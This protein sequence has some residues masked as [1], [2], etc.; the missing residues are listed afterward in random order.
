[1][2][3]NV[4]TTDET[5]GNSETGKGNRASR[6]AAGPVQDMT[7][8]ITPKKERKT[9]ERRTNEARYADPV[10][11]FMSRSFGNG[12]EEFLDTDP[13]PG[14]SY[15]SGEWTFLRAAKKPLIQAFH[16]VTDPETG[17]IDETRSYS[18]E[19]IKT[20]RLYFRGSKAR[21]SGQ[22]IKH[23]F[24]TYTQMEDPNDPTSEVLGTKNFVLID[25][26]ADGKL[27]TAEFN[28]TIEEAG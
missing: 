16:S 7:E 28:S 24:L 25:I 19:A 12:L 18:S 14:A 5:S 27:V 15:N 3:T 8:A 20:A 11:G 22:E 23:R 9:P 2:D 4:A 6:R 13:E 21:E 1:M 17:E 10:E 26:D